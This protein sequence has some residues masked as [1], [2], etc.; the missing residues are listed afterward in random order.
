MHE[1]ALV[2]LLVVYRS[3]LGVYATIVIDSRAPFLSSRFVES[4][5][6]SHG[7]YGR[8][9][10]FE[11][12]EGL[13]KSTAPKVGGRAVPKRP[14]LSP[15]LVLNR[16]WLGWLPNES[17]LEAGENPDANPDVFDRKPPAA[18]DLK[19]EAIA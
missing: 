5:P 14:V 18:P 4:N 3:S 6:R 12:C 16:G 7:F 17:N 19:A 15:K 1:S 11:T 8:S 13:G 10:C 9:S 2:L